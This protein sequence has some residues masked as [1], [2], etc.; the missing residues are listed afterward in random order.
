[1]GYRKEKFSEL[2]KITGLLGIGAFGIVLEVLNKTSNE[3]VAL[4]VITQESSKN[5][6]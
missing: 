3:I 1:M 4:K 6:F 2:Y 5:L